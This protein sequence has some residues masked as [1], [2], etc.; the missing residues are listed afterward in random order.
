MLISLALGIGTNTA[1]FSAV[2]GLLIR[3]IPVADPDELVRL[4][5]SG[6]NDLVHDHSG[7]GSVAPGRPGP[8]L[9]ASFSYPMFEALGA[10]NETLEGL[11]AATS[12]APRRGRAW[13]R[14]R[15]S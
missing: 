7:Y 10:G 3:T 9:S 2:N 8:R 11:F 5:W 13:T 14:T 4:R 15:R 12:S 6:E 1:L